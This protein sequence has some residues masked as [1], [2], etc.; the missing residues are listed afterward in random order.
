M[1]EEFNQ[2]A[3]TL[4]DLLW[5]NVLEWNEWLRLGVT[6]AKQV[7]LAP[8]YEG[9]WVPLEVAEKQLAEKDKELQKLK[10]EYGKLWCSIEARQKI[11]LG[12]VERIQSLEKEHDE[13]EGQ[14]ADIN[15]IVN[16]FPR[17]DGEDIG[18]I[19]F[20]RKHINNWLEQLHSLVEVSSRE[21]KSCE[22]Q[23]REKEKTSIGMK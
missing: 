16:K 20:N 6:E 10:I 14:I 4:S 21:E 15:Q 19:T 17:S 1:S 8:K 9:K 12:T 13:L 11:R 23:K 7:K 18:T 5:E 22:G 3:K 2:K